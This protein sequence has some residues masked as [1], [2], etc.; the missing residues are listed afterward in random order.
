MALVR[1][2]QVLEQVRKKDKPYS[3]PIATFTLAITGWVYSLS[4]AHKP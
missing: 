2:G 3:K 4:V 1:Q